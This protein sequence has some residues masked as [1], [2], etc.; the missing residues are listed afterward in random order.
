[1]YKILLAEDETTVRENIYEILTAYSFEVKTASNGKE[2]LEIL[3]KFTPDLILSDIMMPELDGMGFYTKVKESGKYDDIPFIFLTAKA[4]QADV[5]TGMNAGAEDYIT[6]PF[7]AQDLINSINA[8]LKKKEN[9][10]R[11]MENIKDN[12]AKYVP[13]EFRTP[14]I[15]ILGFSDLILDSSNEFT[16][17][18]ILDMVGKINKSGKRLHSL[19]EKFI[20]Y[21]DI[22]LKLNDRNEINQL[23]SGSYPDIHHGIRTIIYEKIR[24]Y[25]RDND[26][27]IKLDECDVKGDIFYIDLLLGE[28][29]DNAFKFTTAGQAVHVEGKKTDSKYILTIKDY[30]V[31]FDISMVPDIKSFTQY[32]RDVMQQTGLGM[33]LVIAKR[34]AELLNIEIEFYSEIGEY[35]SVTLSIDKE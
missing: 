29:I 7:R 21:S 6:K 10:I 4:Q 33:G 14:L 24:Q 34:I 20:L 32:N 31:G 18:E 13:H 30:G 9:A 27:D 16:L 25:N 15:S 12:I 28:L 17:E 23:I 26:L 2:A 35:T 1:M 22:E 11:R 19:I 3:K 8:R 5:R